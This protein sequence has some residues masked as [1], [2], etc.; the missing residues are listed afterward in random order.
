[1]CQVSYQIFKSVQSQSSGL[2]LDLGPHVGPYHA[3][4]DTLSWKIPVCQDCGVHRSFT[5]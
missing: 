1:M 2:G 4:A 5:H 3:D